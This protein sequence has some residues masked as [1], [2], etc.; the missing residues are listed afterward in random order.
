MES[1]HWDREFEGKKKRQKFSL[2]MGREGKEQF[3]I[4]V[5]S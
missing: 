1:V 2:Q 3:P 4:A 5:N